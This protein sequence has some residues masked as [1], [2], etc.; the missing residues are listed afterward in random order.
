MHEKKNKNRLIISLIFLFILIAIVIIIIILLLRTCNN[1]KQNNNPQDLD[2]YI[3]YYD[4]TEG[5]NIKFGFPYCE[6]NV[7]ALCSITY[8]DI[9]NSRDFEGYVSTFIYEFSVVKY[10]PSSNLNEVVDFQIVQ[11]ELRDIYFGSE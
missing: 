10:N 2:S 7:D 1:K 6:K 5:K 4:D 11:N 3:E 8:D 9:L